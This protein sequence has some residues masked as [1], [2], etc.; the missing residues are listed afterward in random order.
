MGAQLSDNQCLIN[1]AKKKKWQEFVE[2]LDF[3]A[4]S[5]RAWRTLRALD[6]GDTGTPKKFELVVKG[7]TLRGNS[8]KAQAFM[9]HYAAANHSRKRNF[10][11][12][13][14]RILA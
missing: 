6:N 3:T 11:R 8:A 5:S 12:N 10:R 9:Q 4:D 13:H 1:E 2:S 7:R 14:Q